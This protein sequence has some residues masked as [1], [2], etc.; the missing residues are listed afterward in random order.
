MRVAVVENIKPSPLG[1]LGQAL[2]EAG[3]E[4]EVFRPRD[5]CPLPTNPAIHDALIVL[6]GEQSA[7]DDALHPYLPALSRLMRVWGE[8]GRAVLGICLGAQLL[9]RGYGAENRLGA[10]KEFGWRQIRPTGDGRA[11]PVLSAAGAEFPIF[12]WHSDTFVLPDGAKLLA[13]NADVAN[14]AFR[15]G[16]ATYGIQFHFEAGRDIVAEWTEQFAEATEQMRP[17]WGAIHTAEAARHGPRAEAAGLA[18]A[19][20][21]IAQI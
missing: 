5:G 6:G 8:T 14:Q 7:L 15:L 12:Q 10:A 11:D 4:V 3:I 19:R 18:L 20:A 13:T 2:D 17:G 1:L 9:A 21:W 16:R